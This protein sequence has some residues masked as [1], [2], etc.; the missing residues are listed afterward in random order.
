MSDHE[1]TLMHTQKHNLKDLEQI[2]KVIEPK[3]VWTSKPSMKFHNNGASQATS[4]TIVA[5][6]ST[7]ASKMQHP[8][9]IVEH[10]QPKR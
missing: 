10:N 8:Q 4:C 9:Q 5:T 7:Q 1:N 6:I 2:F 3:Y